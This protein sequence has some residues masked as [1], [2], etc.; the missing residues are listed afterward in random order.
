MGRRLLRLVAAVAVSW[1]GVAAADGAAP[2]TMPVDCA[3]GRTCWVMKYVDHDPGPGRRDFRCGR[4]SSDGHQGTDFMIGGMEAM[5]AGVP[6]LAAAP[7]RV[8][9]VRDGMTDAPVRELGVEAVKGRDCGNGIVIDHGD[10]WQSQYCHL[11]RGSLRVAPGDTVTAGQ[12]IALVGLS[13]VS[14]RPHVH[15]TVRHDGT[16]VDPFTAEEAAADSCAAPTSTLWDGGTDLAYRPVDIVAAGITGAPPEGAD[17]R[18]GRYPGTA[19]T[20]AGALVLWTD[21]LD[22]RV[23]DRLEMRLA[24]PGGATL[25]ER[26]MAVDRSTLLAYPYIGRRR[27]DGGWPS[28]RYEGT[29]RVVPGSGRAGA[30]GAGE[31]VERRVELDLP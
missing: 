16:V 2:F 14:D 15:L 1:A 8:L 19:G 21:I 3:I 31:P 13:G 9:R 18:A 20:D 26:E 11:R 22:L 4:K 30:G 25:A 7:G 10:G 6:V 29:I 28:G 5:A 27:P 12:P 24:G 17:M 23:G